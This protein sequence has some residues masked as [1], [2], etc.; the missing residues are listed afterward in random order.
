MQSNKG[1]QWFTDGCI[2]QVKLNGEKLLR[3]ARRACRA[4]RM[5]ARGR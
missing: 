5:A 2:G 1:V 4:S 3:R